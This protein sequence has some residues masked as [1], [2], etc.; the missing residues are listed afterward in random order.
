MNFFYFFTKENIVSISWMF[1]FSCSDIF[2]PH[3]WSSLKKWTKSV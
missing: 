3:S 2:S 1:S